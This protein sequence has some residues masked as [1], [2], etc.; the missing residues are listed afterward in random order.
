MRK[1][2]EHH[3]EEN[4]G[5]ASPH[6]PHSVNY[7]KWERRF[8]VRE[9]CRTDSREVVVVRGPTRVLLGSGEECHRGEARVS[10][11]EWA[12]RDGKGGGRA[13]HRESEAIFSGRGKGNSSLERNWSS[14]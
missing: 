12:E 10:W 11:E 3:L 4:E 9:G 2:N 13:E 14:H 8:S 7:W 1:T 6:L 5:V